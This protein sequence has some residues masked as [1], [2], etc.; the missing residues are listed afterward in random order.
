MAARGL[1]AAGDIDL[2][3]TAE[4]YAELAAA[5]WDELLFDTVGRE[6]VLF[7]GQFDASTGWGVDGYQPSFEELASDA[8]MIDGVPFV[9]LEALA[10]WKRTCRRPKGLADLELIE[11]ALAG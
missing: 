5:G 9:S 1:R 11:R 3:V 10:V 6:R 2:I 7:H 4:L 8:D